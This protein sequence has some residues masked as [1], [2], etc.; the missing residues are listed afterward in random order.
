MRPTY[1]PEQQGFDFGNGF[2]LNDVCTVFD[3][4]EFPNIRPEDICARLRCKS[5]HAM[6]VYRK[7]F[8]IWEEY[9]DKEIVE[10]LRDM[11]N[12][13]PMSV[14]R[15]AIVLGQTTEQIADEISDALNS[16]GFALDQNEI[17]A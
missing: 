14:E 11:P 6:T 17:A 8:E 12:H 2:L 16:L 1:N 10:Y 3:I 7:C 9:V 15:I 13:D 5:D 4:E